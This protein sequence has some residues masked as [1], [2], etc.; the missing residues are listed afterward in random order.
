MT[1]DRPKMRSKGVARDID[2][3]QGVTCLGACFWPSWARLALFGPIL[4]HFRSQVA[5]QL[6]FWT[7]PWP[8]YEL[9]NP[10]RRL[11]NASRHPQ[12]RLKTPPKTPK[13]APNNN[14]NNK[15]RCADYKPIYNSNQRRTTKTSTQRKFATKADKQHIHEKLRC[16]CSLLVRNRPWALF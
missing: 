11:Q 15:H 5:I 13:D 4:G 3:I 7:P 14:N 12:R 6:R 2:Q 10:Q 1:H 16:L 8:N 9:Q